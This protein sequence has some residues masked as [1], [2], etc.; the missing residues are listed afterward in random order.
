MHEIISYD[1][2]K[3]IPLLTSTSQVQMPH[4]LHADYAAI[5]VTAAHCRKHQTLL[6]YLDVGEAARFL[7]LAAPYHNSARYSIDL[8]FPAWDALTM[9]SFKLYYLLVLDNV[10]PSK[11]PELSALLHQTRSP[12]YAS[13]IHLVTRDAHTLTDGPTIF[14]ADDVHKLAQFYVQSTDIPAHILK[15]IMQTIQTNSGLTAEIAQLTKDYA[16]GTQ[17]DEGKEKKMNEGRV[18]PQM[19][20]LMEKIQQAETRVKPVIL[21]PEYVPNTLDH[22]YKHARLAQ[23]RAGKPFTCEI[24]EHQ[25]E[26]IMLIDD[27]A[28]S[29]KL[30][31]LMGIGVF[32]KHESDRYTEIMKQLAQDEKLYLVIASTDYVYGTNYQFC[33]GYIGKDLAEMSQEKCIQAMGR[34]GRNKLQHDYSIRFRDDALLARL[35][36]PGANKPEARNM[37]QLFVRA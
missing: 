4:Y 22:V 32:A 37:A 14:L 6:R 12:R 8:H 35:F 7:A 27:I 29:W 3:T 28:D 13:V 36:Q 15:D 5:K 18:D 20:R 23:A 26:Q 16:D 17:K 11:W 2:K 34:V 19:K 24:G 25:V 21:N 9:A 33:H 1:C 10:V 31:L 30:L